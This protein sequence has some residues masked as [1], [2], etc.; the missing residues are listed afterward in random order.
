MRAAAAQND[1]I[2]AIGKSQ[3]DGGPLFRTRLSDRGKLP[4]GSIFGGL[5]TQQHKKKRRR[6]V[7]P[8]FYVIVTIFILLILTLIGLMIWL[9]AEYA[10]STGKCAYDAAR[11]EAEQAFASAKAQNPDK[12]EGVDY[13]V[14]SYDD[15]KN[16]ATMPP[17]P[18]EIPT[19]T[20][21]PTPTPAAT[22]YMIAESDPNQYMFVPHLEVNG[23][24]RDNNDALNYRRAEEIVFPEA[25]A[26]YADNIKGIL[27]FRGNNWR[28]ASSVGT[29][30]LT[31]YQFTKIWEVKI[32][33]LTK[34]GG[35]GSWSGCG[36]TGQPLI[37]QWPSET[38]RIMNLRDW[39]KEK[40]NLVEVIYPTEDGNIYFIDLETGEQTRDTIK[41]NVPFKGT[42]SIDPRGYPLLYLG[43][44]D[45]YENDSQKSRAFIISLIDGRVLYEFGKQGTDDFARRL[46]Y[47]YD[48]AP[49]IDAKTDTLIYPGENGILYTMKLNTRYDP[50]ARSITVN[51]SDVVKF[52]YDCSNIYDG[53]DKAD[54]AHKWQGY[55]GSAV[56]WNGFLYLSSNDGM[57]QCI[58]LNTMR[59]VWIAD[60]QDDT[61]ASPVLDVISDDEAY[62]Y[63]GTSLHFTAVNSKGVAPF[64]KINAMT[65]KIEKTYGL[66]VETVSGVSGGIQAT[67]AVGRQG[68]NISDL[69]FVT[70]ARYKN[71]D[72]GILVAL[73]KNTFE[74]RWEQ[75]MDG[76]SWSSPAVVYD[77]NGKGYVIQAD[78]KGR[79]T[80][81][82]GASG[83]ILRTIGTLTD[84]N[85]EASPAVFGN[86][87]VVGCRG[88]QKIFGIRLS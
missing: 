72:A 76:Y 45:Q 6:K 60:T 9:I 56:A 74:V 81:Y 8:R 66:T 16:G 41:M 57:F 46:W 35:S 65:G 84:S 30:N 19:P 10:G 43:S 33:S 61:N 32:G 18:T 34:G 54:S 15:Y 21:E 83:D 14:P 68:S 48:S 50:A 71:K 42:G 7:Q 36:W 80:L 40:E 82:D 26:Y 62:L 44:G 67:A 63:V 25:S 59:C 17:A 52:R 85:F 4:A 28:N 87:I 79:I 5:M 70:I 49:L 75:T 24:R 78:S 11:K 31:E 3:K 58:D 86:I 39:A 53:T 73:D 37:V 47:A 23:E 2:R 27:T 13:V 1:W 12:Y 69:V 38:R 29:V 20:P 51:P 88:D 22:P 55:E 64:F 77:T